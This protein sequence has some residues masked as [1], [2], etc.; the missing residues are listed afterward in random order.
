M[1]AKP[2]DRWKESTTRFG[3]SCVAAMVSATWLTCG[4][5]RSSTLTGPGKRWARQSPGYANWS[6]E[7]KPI[8]PSVTPKNGRTPA[9]KPDSDILRHSLFTKPKRQYVISDLQL[10]SDL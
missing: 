5:E 10:L 3:R 9:M 4:R 1:I 2:V 8:L 7:F 6:R